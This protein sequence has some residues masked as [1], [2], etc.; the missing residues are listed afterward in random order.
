M[1]IKAGLV[2]L[3]NVGKST[4]FNALTKSSAP[5]ENYPFCTIDPHVAITNVPDER[6][7]K[8]KAIYKSQEIIPATVTFVDIA[9][10][11]KGAASGEGLGNQFLSHIR[12]VDLII[13]VLRCFEDPN[14]VIHTGETIDPL[15]DLN[16]I[17]HELMLKD[18]ESIEKRLAKIEQTIKKTSLAQEK[19][20]L[21]QEKEL[22]NTS[23][24]LINAMDSDGIKKLFATNTIATIP[25]L[26]AKRSLIVA[27]VGENELDAES[28]SKNEAY[29]SLIKKFGTEYVVPICAKIEAELTQMTEEEAQEIMGLLGMEKSGLDRIIQQTYKML[30]LISFFTCGPKEIHVWPIK[31]G[32]TIR[33]A[34]GEIHSDLEKGFICAEIFNAQDLIQLQSLVKTKEEGKIRTEGQQYIVQDG[35]I[36]EIKFNV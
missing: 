13:H 4:L 36:V 12:E 8:L 24:N 1:A 6:A 26:S 5:A 22:L 18:L 32:I 19:K 30:N 23:L 17:Q 3:P 35:D 28:L 27:N 10:L 34:S 33:Q 20:L 14:I 2:G 16:V 25:L 11:V 15:D 7:H 29:Q 31:K 9:G 21:E